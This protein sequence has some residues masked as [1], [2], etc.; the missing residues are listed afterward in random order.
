MYTRHIHR[1]YYFSF[2]RVLFVVVAIPSCVVVVAISVFVV[3]ATPV[4][5]VGLVFSGP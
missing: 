5:V 1:V 3:V 2:W 4:F